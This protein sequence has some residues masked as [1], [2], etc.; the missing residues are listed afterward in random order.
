[1]NTRWLTPILTLIAVLVISN[2]VLAQGIENPPEPYT[3]S[4]VCLPDAFLTEPG[5]CMALG[6]SQTLT[7]MAKIGLTYPPRPLP[8]SPPPRELAS[9]PV[10]VAKINIGDT[11]PA[12][13]YGTLEDAAAGN[14]PVRQIAPGAGLRYVSYIREQRINDKPFVQ[15]KSGEWMRASPAGYPSFQGLV[16]HKTPSNDFGWMVDHARPKVSPS[17]NAPETGTQLWRQTPV[18]IYEVVEAED[19]LWYMIGPDQWMP[20]QDARRV[21]VN[22]TPPEGV[23]GGR[24]INVDLFNQTVAVYDNFQ[25]VFAT[26]I[27]SGGDPYFTRPGLFPIYEKKPLETMQG[28]FEANRADFYYLEDVPWTM[29]FDQ[30]RA[31]HG[32]YWQDWLGFAGTHGCVNLSIGDSAWLFEWAEVGDWVYVHDPS[33]QTPTDPSLYTAG[34]A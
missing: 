29:Y 13:I 25:L 11:E 18:Q 14:N 9:S 4:A 24:W 32:A 20:W 23:T 15:L 26:L 21:E 22:T 17:W 10:F 28:A 1:M 31:L 34:G 3:G 16:F 7:D 2:T 27:A 30:A 33:G 8:A 5:N 12:M 19:T 6:P